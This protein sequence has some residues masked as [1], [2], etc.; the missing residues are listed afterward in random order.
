MTVCDTK[1]TLNSQTMSVHHASE[2]SSIFLFVL[3]RAVS[4]LNTPPP[5]RTVFAASSYRKGRERLDDVHLR[6]YFADT[7]V[8]PTLY[9][10]LVSDVTESD[11]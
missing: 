8:V 10:V 3:Y 4:L 6:V 1:E 2:H 9:E 5:K 7:I 11:G